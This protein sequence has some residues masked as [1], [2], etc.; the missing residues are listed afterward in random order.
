MRCISGSSRSGEIAGLV[1]THFAKTGAMRDDAALGPSCRRPLSPRVPAEL[2]GGR[3]GKPLTLLL[4]CVDCDQ[5]SESSSGTP[6]GRY[7][8]L[9]AD[10]LQAF[11]AIGV[12]PEPAASRIHRMDPSECV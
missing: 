7:Y 3:Y 9:S 1:A 12:Q 11:Q 6:I 4:R 2:G 10:R 5:A 8:R